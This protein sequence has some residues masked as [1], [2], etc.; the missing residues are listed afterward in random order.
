MKLNIKEL[1][2]YKD[3]LLFLSKRN[4]TS[5]AHSTITIDENGVNT[6]ARANDDTHIKYRDSL[7]IGALVFN[8]LLLIIE[9]W[10]SVDSEC[11]EFI[12]HNLEL[13]SA[14]MEERK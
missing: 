5:L 10:D 11:R 3:M 1:K 8:L 6:N 14:F 4:F 9:K 2:K 12:E 7:V 13:I